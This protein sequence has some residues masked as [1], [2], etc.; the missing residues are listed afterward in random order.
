VGGDHPT[1]ILAHE[2]EPLLIKKKIDE[3]SRQLRW[4]TQ[5]REI[6]TPKRSSHDRVKPAG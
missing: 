2:T 6:M 5:D 1:S 3:A 4:K